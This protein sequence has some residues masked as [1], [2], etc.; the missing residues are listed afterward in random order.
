MQFWEISSRQR[1]KFLT[2]ASNGVVQQSIRLK[3]DIEE[4]LNKKKRYFRTAWQQDFN[5][6]AT[7]LSPLEQFLFIIKTMLN[8][9]SNKCYD[10]PEDILY[11]TAIES[12]VEDRKIFA[13]NELNL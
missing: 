11:S 12:L 1:S 9:F 3:V 4:A 2:N 10:V 6:Q 7:Y 8:R 13:D 5:A